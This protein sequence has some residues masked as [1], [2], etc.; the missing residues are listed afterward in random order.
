MVLPN[1][2]SMRWQR[3][4]RGLTPFGRRGIV[5]LVCVQSDAI[6]MQVN[7]ADDTHVGWEDLAPPS[8]GEAKSSLSASDAT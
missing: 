8:T 6:N 3:T 2:V 4:S 1:V 5:N 7:L